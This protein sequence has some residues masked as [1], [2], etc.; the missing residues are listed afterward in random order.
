M[1]AEQ[2]EL[3]SLDK[4]AILLLSMG[5]DAAAKIMGRLGREE[6]TVLSHRMARLTGVSTN[7]AQTAIQRFFDSFREHSGISAAS[8]DYLERTLDKALGRRLAKSMIDGIYGDSLKDELQKLQWVPESTLARFFETEHAQMQ[9]VLLAF[10][11]PEIASGVLSHL[12]EPAHDELLYRVAA[13][14]DV[15]EQVLSELRQVLGRCMEFVSHSTTASV[16]G[17]KQAAD[18]LNRFEGN[19]AGLMDLLKLHDEGLAVRVSENMYDFMTLSNQ[20]SDVLQIIVQE[21]PEELLALA[22]KGAAPQV[23]DAITAVLPRRMAQSI[24]D[25]IQALGLVPVSR[26]EDARNEMMRRV[27]E[28]NEAEVIRYQIFQEK[29]VD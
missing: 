1:D 28:L 20:S 9:A 12:P 17:V 4:A 15:S 18:I 11:P 3:N 10:L 19:R 29:V 14:Q 16:D 27:R 24:T 2:A 22:L 7:D 23:R 13:M 26:V 25:R 21:V 5:E 8:R 6:V